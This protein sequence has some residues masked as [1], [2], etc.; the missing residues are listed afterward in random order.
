MNRSIRALARIFDQ[1]VKEPAPVPLPPE[2]REDPLDSIILARHRAVRN[3]ALRE[4]TSPG[5][6]DQLNKLTVVSS[7]LSQRFPNLVV[8]KCLQ[9]ASSPPALNGKVV[10]DFAFSRLVALVLVAFFPT[11]HL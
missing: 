6:L 2:F 3:F 1:V 9:P 4:Q 10:A 8:N 5:V 7:L 11:S